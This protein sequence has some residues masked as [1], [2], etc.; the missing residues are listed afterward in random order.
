V[1]PDAR[2]IAGL[3]AGVVGAVAF[4]RYLRATF[5]GTT[6]PNRATWWILTVVG[7]LLAASYYA[8]GARQTMWL[9]VSYALCPLVTAIVS[10]KH[11]EGG[12]TPFDRACLLGAGISVVL[13]WLCRSPLVALLINLF[14]DFVGLLPTIRKSYQRPASEDRI[15]WMI[16]LLASIINLF[17]VERWAFALAVYPLYMA[18][19]NGVIAVLLL[20]RRKNAP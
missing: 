15:A 14:I 2:V 13:W 1:T 11:G 17:A 8:S 19:G 4:V 16:G 18:L 6:K 20:C 12:W 3:L 10:L 5:R 7:F 9:P